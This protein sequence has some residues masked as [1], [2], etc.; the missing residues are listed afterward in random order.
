MLGSGWEFQTHSQPL[1]WGCLVPLASKSRDV[2]VSCPG[3]L[4][5]PCLS[6]LPLIL[7]FPHCSPSINWCDICGNTLS[8]RSSQISRCF[9]SPQK[10]I[11]CFSWLSFL[12]PKSSIGKA[13]KRHAR[14]LGQP[15]DSW[16]LML[17]HVTPTHSRVPA[18]TPPPQDFLPSKLFRPMAH[19]TATPKILC[20][21]L[22]SC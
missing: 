6:L 14:T 4:V 11:A 17:N 19:P 22:R 3:S 1:H 12:P 20:S 5:L 10:G 13:L 9:P 16:Q 21:L 8:Q 18:A 15:T 2:S 7:A